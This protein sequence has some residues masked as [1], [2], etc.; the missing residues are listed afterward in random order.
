[1][2]EGSEAF[3]GQ[4][5][6]CAPGGRPEATSVVFRVSGS[7]VFG[8]IPAHVRIEALKRKKGIWWMPWHR[9]AMKDVAPCEKLR[10]DGSDR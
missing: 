2:L 6:A 7:A 10:G 5:G 4:Y 8:F 3:G 9:E 1:L